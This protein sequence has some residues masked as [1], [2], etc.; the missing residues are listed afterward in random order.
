MN[1]GI[2]IN[3]DY[4]GLKQTGLLSSIPFFTKS[5]HQNRILRMGKP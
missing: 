1:W 2:L 4:L 5:L 3:D